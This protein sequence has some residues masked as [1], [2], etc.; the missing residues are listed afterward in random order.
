MAAHLSKAL[1]SLPSGFVRQLQHCLGKPFVL[2]RPEELL[3][4]NCDAYLLQQALPQLVVLPSTSQQVQQ[5][6][7]L[8][9]QYQIPFT[10][11]GAGTGLSGG[12]LA[13]QGGV[14]V[15]LNRMQQLMTLDEANRT[16]TVQ[17]GLVNG[18]LNERLAHSGLFFAPDPSSQ[19]ASTLGGNIA[20]NAGGIHCL[21]YGVTTDHI[22]A[23]EMVTP[24][25][26]MVWVGNHQRFQSGL[27]W[28]RLLTGSEGT[29]GIVTQA[30]VQLTPIPQAIQV[31]LAAFPSIETAAHCVSAIMADTETP[32]IAPAALELMDAFTV[33]CVNEA[34]QVG[35]PENSQAV[36]LIELDGPQTSVAQRGQRLHQLLVHHQAQQ[37]RHATEAAERHAL[38]QARKKAVASYGRFYPAFYLHDCVIPRSQLAPVLSQI[39][40]ICQHHQVAIANVFHAGDGN[41]HPHLLFHPQEPGINERVHA[42]GEAIIECCLK[43]GGT[44]SGEHGIG[45][46]KSHLMPRVFSDADMAAMQGLKIAF[47]P[48][49]RC[50]PNKIFPTRS[51]CGET[52]V[53]SKAQTQQAA[54]LKKGLWV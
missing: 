49:Q 12:A 36:L 41:L 15:A 9:N 38:W 54:L 11:R 44:L 17:A 27:P 37:I 25:G 6:V 51:S 7:W 32:A 2:T 24:E 20:E 21:G 30:V 47:D 18:H 26:D 16:A 19:S 42:A 28:T 22:L 33:R 45:I 53:L 1:P 46:E 4:Y 34:F 5:V 31:F 8:C 52:H 43:A 40:A 29:M 13:I 50:N 35:F 10:P 48:H 14:L 3:T 39:I 23:L